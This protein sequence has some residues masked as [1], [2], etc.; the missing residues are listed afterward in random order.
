MTAAS[1]EPRWRRAPEARPAQILT[2]ALEEFGA[3]GLTRARLE[4]IARR[5]GVSK[6]TIYVYFPDKESLFREVV[7]STVVQTIERAEQAPMVGTPT[8]QLTAF[9]QRYWAFLRT[10]AFGAIYR[11][12]IAEL[13]HFPELASFYSREVIARGM[14][15]VVD[16]IRRGIATGEF[17]AVDPEVAARAMTA[18]FITHA[19]WCG[20]RACFPQVG[21]RSD[22]QVLAEI[23]SLTLDTILRPRAAR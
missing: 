11:M 10:P 4:D 22:D 7:R 18:M 8:E 20:D 15:L 2:A 9:M 3:V 5:A 19:A 12:V 21:D 17:R 14:R 6:G 1:P 16:I 13:R 23:Q